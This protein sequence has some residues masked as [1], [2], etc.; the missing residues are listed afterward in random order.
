MWEDWEG[1]FRNLIE[2]HSVAPVLA[3]VP[4]VHRGQ[5][6][7]IAAAVIL[8]AAAFCVS[9]L[10]AGGSP[11][12]LL[13]HSTGV[14][15]LRLIAAQL[16]DRRVVAMCRTVDGRWLEPHRLRWCLRSVGCA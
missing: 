16:V 6:W 4:T 2:T 14:R 8:D 5:T 15:A 3:F 9:G 10:E 13:C 7:L 1:W 12:A 11:S